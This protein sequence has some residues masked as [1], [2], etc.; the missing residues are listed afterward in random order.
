[1]TDT[2][3][4]CFLAICRHK[5]VSA[6]AQSLYITQPSL[7]ARLKVLEREVGAQLFYRCKGSRE[8]A[9]TPAGTEFYELAVEYEK[10]I[11]KMQSLGSRQADILRV[12]CFNSLGTYLF[13]EVCQLFLQTNPNVSLETQDMEIAA[14][15]QSILQ[16]ETDLAFTAGHVSDSQLRQIPVFLEPMVLVC[17][18][19]AAGKEPVKLLELPHQEEVFV[20]WSYD[21]SRWHQK[22][23]H[24]IRPQLGA[25]M[26]PQL[27]KFLEGEGRWSIVPVSVAKGLARE[28]VIR[29]VET[30]IPLPQ[31]EISCVISAQRATPAMNRFLECLRQVLTTY[32]QIEVF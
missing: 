13:P 26:M 17:A 7:S 18:G 14:A 11:Q 29:E 4:G 22:T 25:S 30:D 2:G 6:A 12:S 3:I 5:T 23:F 10:L 8:M 24:I 19:A 31:R 1:M 21:F 20:P 16:A 32:P 27:R 15:C 28:C 9:L